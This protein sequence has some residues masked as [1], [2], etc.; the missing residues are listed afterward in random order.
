M[1]RSDTITLL[2][3]DRYAQIMQLPLPHFN[4][5][6]GTKAPVV[7]SNCKAIWDQNARD[8]LAWTMAQAEEMIAEFLNFWPSPKFIEDEEIAL[9]LPGI[10]HDWWHAE[11]QTRYAQIE[12]FGTELLTL[13]RANAD[14][15]YTNS[16]NNP[17]DRE[18]LATISSTGL[19]V[20]EL[21]ACDSKCEVAVFFREWSY[22]IL[23]RRV[24]LW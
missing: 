11:V 22:D 19:Y 24:I 14:V 6:N 10:R 16:N 3:L 20:D 17:N 5:M 8:A 9:S 21:A 13:K 2:P 15:I 7:N 12:C 18:N 23:I 1:A 4:Q